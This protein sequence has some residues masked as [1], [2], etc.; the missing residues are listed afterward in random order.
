MAGWQMCAANSPSPKAQRKRADGSI[1]D[2]SLKQSDRDTLRPMITRSAPYLLR[3]VVV[4]S[5][6]PKKSFMLDQST[7]LSRYS[8]SAEITGH[9]LRRRVHA[10][11]GQDL[12]VGHLPRGT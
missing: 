12:I 1:M 11:M 8:G 7:H 9:L 5:T 6:L 2:R 10:A 4:L 3:L